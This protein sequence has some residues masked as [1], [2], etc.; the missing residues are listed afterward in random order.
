MSAEPAQTAL[1]EPSEI[2][3]A[4]APSM[5]QRLF[6]ELSEADRPFYRVTVVALAQQNRLRPVFLDRKPKPERHLWMQKALSRKSASDSA[7]HIIQTWLV[8]C[9]P[10]IL[11]RFLDSLDIPHDEDGTVE[12]F[13]DSPGREALEKAADALLAGD[14]PDVA[15]IYLTAFCALNPG[16]WPEFAEIVA[17]RT[18]PPDQGLQTENATAN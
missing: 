9:H 1:T 3:R 6:A 14:E 5:A 10:A 17:A 16:L 13:P 2:F 8:K 4:M 18:A 12:Q 11:C 15:R 7:G